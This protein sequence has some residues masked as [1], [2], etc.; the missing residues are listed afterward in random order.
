MANCMW[1]ANPSVAGVA[2]A[3]VADVGQVDDAMADERASCLTSDAIRTQSRRN[4]AAEQTD[5][6]G[7]IGEQPSRRS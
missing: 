2:G 4:A 5:G 1:S 3:R 6:G 7:K